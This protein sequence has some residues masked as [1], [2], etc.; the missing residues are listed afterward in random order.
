MS[1]PT[2]KN[3]V[4]L[5]GPTPWI[6]RY[7]LLS[8]AS[9]PKDFTRPFFFFAVFF[10]VAHNGLSDRGTTRSLMAYI[11]DKIM[12]IRH[13]LDILHLFIFTLFQGVIVIA[14]GK[15]KDYKDQH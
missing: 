5:K 1:N 13:P 3:H 14:F 6:R 7:S 12:W 9:R 2:P 10:Y 15:N 4:A 11:V 8:R